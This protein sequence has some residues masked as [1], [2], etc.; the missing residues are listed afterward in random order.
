[1]VNIRPKSFY[2][3]YENDLSD[4]L[5]ENN[6]FLRSYLD[7]DLKFIQFKNEIDLF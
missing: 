4:L 5:L 1:M 3:F 7:D 2:F 6:T